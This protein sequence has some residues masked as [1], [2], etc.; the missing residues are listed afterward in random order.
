MAAD[1]G[2]FPP[3]PPHQHY[4]QNPKAVNDTTT[5]KNLL[6]SVFQ[7]D[8]LVSSTSQLSDDRSMRSTS[9]TPNTL[10]DVDVSVTEVDCTSDKNA[11]LV[12]N[13]QQ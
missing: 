11:R 8:R 5:K 2:T 6:R 10:R 13:S 4:M 7:R 3:P 9:L 12:F 1:E